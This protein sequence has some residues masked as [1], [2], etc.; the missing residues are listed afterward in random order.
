MPNLIARLRQ[1]LRL[2]YVATD[3]VSANVAIFL[4]NMARS[5]DVIWLNSVWEFYKS[6]TVVWGQIFMPLALMGIFW[7]S[8]YY[9]NVD[10]RSRLQELLT[11][12][13]SVFVGALLIFFLAMVNDLPH[14]RTLAINQFLRLVA[15]LFAVVYLGRFMI[16]RTEVRG[17]HRR[18]KFSDAYMIGADEQAVR[19]ALGFNALPKG[20]GMRI[21]TLIRLNHNAPLPAN[22]DK[23]EIIDY[24]DIKQL[25]ANRALSN[26]ILSPALN[27]NRNELIRVLR[28]LLPLNVNI[29]MKPDIDHLPATANRTYDIM[30][31]PLICLSS[32]HISPSAANLKRLSDI[33]LSVFALVLLSP[34][35]LAMAIAIKL[36]DGGPVFFSQE[37][38]GL[39]NVP[40]R[41][42]KLRSMQVNAEQLGKPLLSS[43]TDTRITRVGRFIRKYRI[44]EIPQFANVILGQM[45]IV[46]PRPERRHFAEILVQRVPYYHL[47]YQVR[48][49]IT[50]W[51]MVRYGY[52]STIDQ[53]V[54]RLRYDLIYIEN[55]SITTDVKIMIHTLNTVLSGSGK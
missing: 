21:T 55:I 24:S 12:F 26:L 34:L 39:H 31:E 25:S 16:T 8:G 18:H 13:C 52:A 49:G 28:R 1:R 37:R 6:P 23:F 42:F 14:D 32:P 47:I 5:A 17:V 27:H 36:D 50:S 22:A 45:S 33:I 35:L 11:T 30:G 38:M 40:F 7:L 44:D 15:I 48:P 53:M 29:F 46:G 43:D 3:F 51:G 41:I 10:T 4:F 2:L 54:E 19:F 20:T 9:N